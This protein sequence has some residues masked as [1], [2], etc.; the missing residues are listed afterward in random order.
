MPRCARG[1]S[2]IGFLLLQNTH[3]HIFFQRRFL[4]PNANFND[5]NHRA[6]L[7]DC[8]GTTTTVTTVSTAASAGW[9]LPLEGNDAPAASQ[10]RR[11]VTSFYGETVTGT[12]CLFKIAAEPRRASARLGSAVYVCCA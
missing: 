9:L 12:L 7:I 5:C 3:H 2:L 1:H 11:F 8:T 4:Y 10:P 6:Y